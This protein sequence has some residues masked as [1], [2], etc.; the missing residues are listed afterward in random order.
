M[1]FI[2]KHDKLER[3]TFGI[4][5]GNRDVFPDTLAKQGRIVIVELMENLGFKYVI[6]S[7]DDTKFGVVE[8]HSDAKNVL[9]FSN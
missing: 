1:S 5:V 4:I 2:D 3:I 9:N 7:E 8:T 6:L